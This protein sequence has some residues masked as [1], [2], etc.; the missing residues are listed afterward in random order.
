MHTSVFKSI[1][2]LFD[3]L[4]YLNNAEELD[5][6]YRGPAR[7]AKRSYGQM[8]TET[9]ELTWTLIDGT[10]RIIALPHAIMLPDVEEKQ[11]LAAFF[12]LPWFSRTWILQEVGLAS[13]AVAKWEML[14]LSGML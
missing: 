7:P 6:I 9:A 8:N 14:R 13:H 3:S 10:S 4:L 11:R 1:K 12:S 5:E 2:A